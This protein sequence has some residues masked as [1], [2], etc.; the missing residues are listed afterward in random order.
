MS[1]RIDGKRTKVVATIGPSSRDETVLRQ[2]IRNGMD[3]ARIN[4]S[5]GDHETHGK[6]IDDV[7]RI[8]AEEGVVIAILCDI[9]GPKIRIGKIA[10]EPIPLR[11][12]DKLTL[13]LDPAD[14]TN[15]VIQ[16]PHPEFVKDLKPGMQ[17]LLDDGKYEFV[18]LS[19]MGRSMVCEVVIGGDLT[20]R[21]GIMAPTARLTMPAIT[22][23]DRDDTIFAVS[24]K[25]EYL[26]M[27]FVR[28]P[29]DIREMRWLLRHLGGMDTAIIAKIE[30]HEAL[31]NIEAIIDA[32]DGVMVARGDL[33]VEIPAEEVPFHQKRI[34][35][36][37]NAA[38][39]PV[40]T[41][42]QMLLSMVDNPRP[43][44]AEASDVY[45][46]I[47]DGTDAVML[48]NE[49]AN[50]HYPARSVETMVNIASIAENN[51]LLPKDRQMRTK[52]NSSESEIISDAVSQ[53]T[54]QVAETLGCRAIITATMSGYTTR[55]IAK[56]RPRTPILCVTPNELT[57][58]RMAL[59]WGVQP[60]MVPVF[61]SIDD[62]IKVVVRAAHDSRLIKRGDSL[63]I[64]AGVPFGMA[65]QTNFLKIHMAGEAGELDDPEA[66]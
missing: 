60:I 21:K 56:E 57:Y 37:C 18:V 7:R 59:V 11:P 63:V 29:D 27:S 54:V 46:A 48:S 10:N 1:Q 47:L 49:T 58:R 14:G 45:N 30:K 31:E 62:M 23:K 2:M 3:V 25:T 41:A 19:V 42:T 26:A 35:R 55:Q 9:Q 12:G 20:S 50:G 64:I 13:T 33:G 61:E 6:A 24:K 39:K 51:I 4:F 16:L 44:R 34:I 17:L 32:T 52:K 40:I 53:A 22:D 15:N 66:Q 28:S 36:L 43:T 65:G 8:A 38:G 5:H